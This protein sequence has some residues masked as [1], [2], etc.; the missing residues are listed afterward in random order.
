MTTYDTLG[1]AYSARR[2]GD[3]RIA[4][5]I[6][7]A[8]GSAASVLN[9]GA[10][11]GS[12][13]PTDR[14]VIALE[15]SRVMIAQRPPGAAPAICGVAEQLPFRD[16]QFDAVLGILT[17]HH[18]TDQR[19]G[20]A[21]CRRVA[22]DHVVLLTWDPTCNDYW[23]IR[24]YFPEFQALDV[25]RFATFAE[26][27]AMMGP[28]EM[29]DV[30][31]PADCTDGFLGAYWRRPNAYLDPVV[32]SGISSLHDVGD[33]DPR[34]VRLRRDIESGAWADRHADLLARTT[35]DIGYRIV[36]ALSPGKRTD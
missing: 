19:R 4:A 6:R 14:A 27:S 21:E 23:F 17:L 9:V 11:T 33:D 3:P 12:Y 5:A 29:H 30:P 24:E 7:A 31:I 22:R 32:R 34:L 18:W 2:H 20:L 16:A 35:F 25:S 10:G 1:R 8:L 13:E 26:L 15:P 28:I 36:V